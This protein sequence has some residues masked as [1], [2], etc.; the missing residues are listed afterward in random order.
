MTDTEASVQRALAQVGKPYV[1]GA[2]GP[3]SF[4]CSG[5]VYYSYKPDFPDIGRTTFS[6]V[7]NG[8]GVHT[9]QRGDLVLPY[10]DHITIYIGNGKLLEAPQPGENVHIIDDYIPNPMAI[11]RLGP[12]NGSAGDT[13]TKGYTDASS[14]WYD[15]LGEED[16]LKQDVSG[17]KQLWKEV[18]GTEQ[19]IS[20]VAGVLMNPH[21]WIRFLKFFTGVIMFGI[22]SFMILDN[23]SGNQVSDT[24]SNVISS[25]NKYLKTNTKTTSNMMKEV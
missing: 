16:L 21:F 8:T 23:M 7:M 24:S 22:G 10:A 19:F 4:D 20:N 15:P 12:N 11:R 3:D 6:Q 25:A 14:H 1:W 17:M 2:T 18:A 9:K 13:G 5:L